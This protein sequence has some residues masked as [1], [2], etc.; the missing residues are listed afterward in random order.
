MLTGGRGEGEAQTSAVQVARCGEV[1][2]HWVDRGVR[3]G[4]RRSRPR[5]GDATL[6]ASRVNRAASLHFSVLNQSCHSLFSAQVKLHNLETACLA[7]D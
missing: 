6:D 3:L 7:Q 1:D 4:K 5:H 2:S